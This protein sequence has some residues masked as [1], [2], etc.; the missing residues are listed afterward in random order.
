MICCGMWIT[1]AAPTDTRCAITLHL[2]MPMVPQ[3]ENEAHFS[4]VAARITLS[5]QT[6]IFELVLRT[7]F[8]TFWH[9]LSQVLSPLNEMCRSLL[10]ARE[11]M[12]VTA[13][14]A[15]GGALTLLKWYCKKFL[16]PS[17]SSE[18]DVPRD[19]IIIIGQCSNLNCCQRRRLPELPVQLR[20]DPSESPATDA[21]PGSSFA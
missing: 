9:I 6:G 16:A 17:A 20:Q 4:N 18:V 14:L 13:P 5:E 15:R 7:I 12:H 1:K 3:I 19:V 21:S 2:M 11:R 10:H 8:L